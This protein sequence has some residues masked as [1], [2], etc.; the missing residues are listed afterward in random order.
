MFL[1]LGHQYAKDHFKKSRKLQLNVAWC[2]F[3]Q[4]MGNVQEVMYIYRNPDAHVTFSRHNFTK[5]TIS[6]PAICSVMLGFALDEVNYYF[7]IIV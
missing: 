1:L 3:V 2:R 4:N 7:E 6:Y 5:V